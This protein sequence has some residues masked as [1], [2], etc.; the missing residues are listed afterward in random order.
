M[1]LQH[2]R[3][4]VVAI[5]VF[6]IGAQVS[7]QTQKSDNVSVQFGDQTILIPTP[8]GLLE[9]TGKSEIVVSTFRATEPSQTIYSRHTSLTATCN[10]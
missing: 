10:G 2:L 8:E 1:K 6:A 7:S 4:L 3:I 9:V 5:V